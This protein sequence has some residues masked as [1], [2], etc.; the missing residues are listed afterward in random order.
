V[1]AV[2]DKG[3]G[4][5]AVEINAFS[6]GS[7][8]AVG[9]TNALTASGYAGRNVSLNVIDPFMANGSNGVNDLDVTIHDFR[10][11]EHDLASLALD[12]GA[13]LL[14]VGNRNVFQGQGS[15]FAVTPIQMQV[16]HT[17][18]D[19]FVPGALGTYDFQGF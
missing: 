15:D 19:S 2:T 17:R 1:K 13:H 10:G 8:P 4:E 9:L 18:M 16:P 14:G 5:M 11:A 12:A 7:G 3:C 6:L